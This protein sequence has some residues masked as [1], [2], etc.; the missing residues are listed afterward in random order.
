[1][2]H[3]DSRRAVI[4]RLFER[5]LDRPPELRRSFLAEVCR[6]DAGLLREVEELLEA[7]EMDEPLFE[8]LG[9][10]VAGDLGAALSGGLGAGGG[11]PAGRRVGPYRLVAEIGRGGMAVVYLAERADGQFE[12]RVALKLVRS[13]IASDEVL[14][15]FLRE[16]QILASLQHPGIARLLDG[17]VAEDGRPFFA[18]EHVEGVPIDRHCRERRSTLEERLRLFV[19][20]GRAVEHAHARL[21][22][23]RDLKPSNILVTEDGRVKL[24]DFGIARLLEPGP[25]APGGDLTRTLVRVMT[26]E[27]ASPEQARGEPVG[28]ASDVYQLGLLLY[29]LLTGR[30][31]YRIDARS[32][33]EIERLISTEVPPPPS[34]A[35]L[36]RDAA[37]GDAGDE[38]RPGAS[39]PAL[40]RRL[41][42]DLDNIVA[43]ALRKEPERRYA[44]VERLV[45][46]VERHLD[47]R[48]V[49]AHPDSLRYR[50]GKFLRRHRFGVA[51][52]AVLA[53]MVVGYA[54]TVT[55]QARALLR[56]RDRA[57]AEAT[58]AEE[59]QRFLLDLFEVADPAEARGRDVTV[60]E[61]LDR[62]AAGLEG[63]LGDQPAVQAELARSIGEIYRRLG[64]YD[65][66]GTYL[67]RALD[68]SRRLRPPDELEEAESLARLAE[69]ERDRGDVDRS[70]ALSRRS[71]AERLRHLPR[72]SAKVAASLDGLGTA[73]REQGALEESERR[74]REA[75]AIRRSILGPNHPDVASTLNSLG[76]TLHAR[77]DD[78]AAAKLL[79]EALA[80]RRRALAK[81]HPDLITSIANLAVVL[82]QEGDYAGSERLYREALAANRRVLGE[83]HP[84]TAITMSNLALTLRSEGKL[85]EA[86]SILQRALEI[87]RATLGPSHPMVAANLNDLGRVRQDAGDLEGAEDLYRQA[88]AAYP[89]GHPWR[90]IT[91]FNLATVLSAQGD[92][93]EALALLR[94]TLD[95]DRQLLGEDH[96]SVAQDLVAVARELG[97]LGDLAGAEPLARQALAIDRAKLPAR[98]RQVAEALLVLGEILL[99]RGRAGE[100]EPLLR[101]ALDVREST[102]GPDAAKTAEVRDALERCRQAVAGHSSDSAGTP[103]G[104]AGH[105]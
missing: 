32:A 57:Q 101:E 27:Y 5:V 16:R 59:V 23:H 84:Y 97:A 80:I 93:Q 24:L 60:R 42:G 2:S 96:P 33:S 51:A 74:L 62:G 49:A 31:A 44:S 25:E 12:Q 55:T 63:R 94:K 26:P 79:G 39:A 29:R 48:P 92:H 35:V 86:T 61:L 34:V 99:D 1:M 88:L 28:T 66:A 20:A 95:R 71:L 82:R 85:D 102:L 13:E 54:V 7:A 37:A 104:S 9:R 73:L 68:L 36:R 90:P 6:S 100:A 41:A 78:A 30:P 56:E 65:Q 77:G 18:M 52:A 10:A 105:R 81:D 67:D 3:A 70:V 15:R 103:S 58:K 40:A 17:G 72:R 69:L 43:M 50:A 8:R 64:L 19:A 46:D 76:Q 14:R 75:L 83:R 22:I 98:H 53:L 87:R 21:V 47:G 4:D 11:D 89:S 45:E 91:E 38:E